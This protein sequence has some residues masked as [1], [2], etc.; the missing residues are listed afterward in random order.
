MKEEKIKLLCIIPVGE[1]R[2]NLRFKEG[3]RYEVVIN[4]PNLISII[5]EFGYKMNFVRRE[6]DI[7]NLPYIWDYFYEE[8]MEL[9]DSKIEKLK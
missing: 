5:D 2:N 8:D 6:E 7:N 9:L 3:K 1:D 4:H